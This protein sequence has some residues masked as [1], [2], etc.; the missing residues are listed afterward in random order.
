MEIRISE[1]I[2]G[3]APS[4]T[5]AVTTRA[6]EMAAQGVDVINFGLG[7]P[8]FDTPA[9]IKEAAWKALQAGDTKYALPVGGKTPLREALRAY[10]KSHCGLDYALPQIHVSVGAKDAI[11][12]TFTVLLEA[13]DEVI[14]PVPYWVSYPDQVRLAGGNPIL[15]PGAGRGGRIT[16]EQLRGAITPRTRVLVMNSPSNPSGLMYSADEFAALAGVL[17]DTSVL[18]LSDELYHRLVLAGGTCPSFAAAPGMYERTITI[19]GFSKTYAMPGW[20][21]GFAAGP[22]PV[23][24]A[25]GRLQG[26]TTS[27]AVNFVQTAAIAALNGDQACVEEMR[28][29]YARRGEVMWR[30]L[31]AIPGVRCERPEGGFVCFPDVSG[32]LSRLGMKSA[33]EFAM[34]VLERAHV[35]IVSGTAFGSAS[36]VRF[37][38]AA[39]MA[40]VEEGMRRI[41]RFLA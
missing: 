15:V 12:Q 25:M 9:H 35:A 5:L 41:E 8:D 2:R 32:V 23:I 37:S 3:L 39:S 34:A 13:G 6:K 40:H 22:A 29:E 26:Q 27:G 10:L 33:D 28:R 19:N 16:P 4:A 1:R 17:R 21:L 7:E 18:V 36:H 31:T 11:L 30:A 20:R 24:A 38:F 14:I